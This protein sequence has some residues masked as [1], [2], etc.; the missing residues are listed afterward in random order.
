MDSSVMGRGEIMIKAFQLGAK[1]DGVDLIIANSSAVWLLDNNLL[2][3]RHD[4]GLDFL[5]NL[6]KESLKPMVIVIN[7]GDTTIRWKVET[8]LKGQQRC[9]EAGIPVYPDIQRASRALALFTQYYRRLEFKKGVK[10]PY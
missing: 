2:A 7:S 4:Q 6:A 5:I 9:G 1:W 10:T 8:L 3:S